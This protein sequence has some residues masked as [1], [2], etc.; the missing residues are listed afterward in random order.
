MTLNEYFDDFGRQGQRILIQVNSLLN[1]YRKKVPYSDK[2]FTF[3]QY[4][5]DRVF[6]P[7]LF[8]ADILVNIDT[9][10]DKVVE[11][12]KKYYPEPLAF[13]DKF[14]MTIRSNKYFNIQGEKC[15]RQ[16]RNGCIKSGDFGICSK[17]YSKE[18]DERKGNL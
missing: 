14:F 7:Y 15:V 10:D 9:M 4:T 13:K 17:S 16:E 6:S 3:C 8:L 5:V 1:V 11:T 12:L 2:R 18:K